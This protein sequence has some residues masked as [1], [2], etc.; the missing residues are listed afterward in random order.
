MSQQLPPPPPGYRYV[1]TLNGGAALVATPAAAAPNGTSGRAYQ[2]THGM[3]Q[4]PQERDE[5]EH[6]PGFVEIPAF[7]TVSLT[8]G[9][10][11]GA[12]AGESTKIRPEDFILRRITWATN[13]D[14]PVFVSVPSVV[15]SAQGRCVEVSWSD[16]FTKFLG[17]QACLVSALFGDSQGFLD[18]PKK[19]LLFQGSQALQV[20]LRRLIWPDPETDPADTRWDFC[21]QGVMLLPKGI[22]QSGSAG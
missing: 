9:G 1:R 2:M 19:G 11:A 13:G 6:Y 14:A 8:L 12:I 22:N 15:G 17:T 3:G 5:S 18:M 4:H 16:E 7:Y 21:F 20:N 10:T